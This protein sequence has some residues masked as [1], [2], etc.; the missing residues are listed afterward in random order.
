MG[1]IPSQPAEGVEA[2]L[3]GKYLVRERIGQGAFG[4]V[5][6]LEARAGGP[7]RALKIVGRHGDNAET[8][9]AECAILQQ[10]D[11]RSC[12]RLLAA[13]TSELGGGVVHYLILDLYVGGEL[14]ER[15]DQQRVLRES[16]V[17][18]CARQM[19]RALVYLEGLRV[20]HRDVKPANFM[21]RSEAELDL[22]LIDFGLAAQWTDGPTLSHP[23][24]T[25]H[26]VAPEMF[27]GRYSHAAHILGAG[28]D[29]FLGGLRPVKTGE[30]P[31]SVVLLGEAPP[32]SVGQNP[33]KRRFCL[34]EASPGPVR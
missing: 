33:R 2:A 19:C 20:V 28:T 6:R 23:C 14:L 5:W 32:Q 24:G 13:Y 34:C 10:I 1:C 30:A 27:R 31:R 3:S 21:F 8:G 9:T 15:I 16:T 29:A 7:D 26:Y 22:V 11:H 17:A 12:T 18:D 4:T 25:L